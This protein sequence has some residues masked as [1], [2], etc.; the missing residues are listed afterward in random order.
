M[1]PVRTRSFW[2]GQ[3]DTSCAKVATGVRL[4]IAARDTSNT[5]TS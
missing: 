1:K 5:T 2:Y 3:L 4:A